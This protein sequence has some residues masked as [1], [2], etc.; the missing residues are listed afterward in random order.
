[1]TA[2]LIIQRIHGRLTWAIDFADVRTAPSWPVP[3]AR[4]RLTE[5]DIKLGGRKLF[6]RWCYH[7]SIERPRIRVKAKMRRAA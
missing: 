7:G 2:H 4:T 3:I 5:D 1:M 6:W